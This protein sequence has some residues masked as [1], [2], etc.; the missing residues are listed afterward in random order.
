[1]KSKV[2]DLESKVSLHETITVLERCI[3]SNE[4]KVKYLLEVIDC[5][6]TKNW[7]VRTYKRWKLSRSDNQ[8]AYP[9]Y[10][11]EVTIES[12]LYEIDEL[13]QLQLEVSLQRLYLKEQLVNEITLGSSFNPNVYTLYEEQKTSKSIYTVEY[14]E[15]ELEAIKRQWIDLRDRLV[16]LKR[17]KKYYFKSKGE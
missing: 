6:L 5:E 16:N 9:T 14:S 12:V 7:F 4:L 13:L 3:E 10:D 1:M 8:Y 2:F 17:F 11:E 15:K